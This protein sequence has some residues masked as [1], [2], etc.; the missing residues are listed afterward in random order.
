MTAELTG[1]TDFT[2]LKKLDCTHNQLTFS[3]SGRYHCT[4]TNSLV[5]CLTLQSEYFTLK[6]S[7]PVNAPFIVSDNELMIYANSSENI[8]RSTCGKLRIFYGVPD[9]L[10]V[11]GK[12]V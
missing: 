2:S 5:T 6:V 3:D 9:F 1:I 12:N 4:I 11:A 7:A 8:L 10:D